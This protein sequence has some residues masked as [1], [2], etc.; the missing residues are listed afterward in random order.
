[1]K[2]QRCSL[3]LGVLV[4]VVAVACFLCSILTSPFVSEAAKYFAL[5]MVVFVVFAIYVQLQLRGR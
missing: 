4:V 2:C 3:A 1:M 5:T